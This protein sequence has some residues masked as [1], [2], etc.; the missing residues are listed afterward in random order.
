MTQIELI[1][2][3]WN[4][5]KNEKFTSAEV[6]VYMYLLH[7]IH[8]PGVGNPVTIP[9]KIICD[10]LKI[11]EPTLISVMNS[12]E[13]KEFL[14]KIKPQIGVLGVFYYVVGAYEVTNVD[15]F[16]HLKILSTHLKILSTHLNILST[17]L[18]I[19]STSPK[20]KKNENHISK[21]LTATLLDLQVLSEQNPRTHTR[22]RKIGVFN[23]KDIRED[24]EKNL[25]DITNHEDI[26]S[27]ISG[28]K[29]TTS[30]TENPIAIIATQHSEYALVEEEEKVRSTL[31]TSS[32]VHLPKAADETH[33]NNN[34]SKIIYEVVQPEIP[35]IAIIAKKTAK[36][37]EEEEEKEMWYDVYDP[38]AEKELGSS[39]SFAFW[40]MTLLP[41]NLQK[42]VSKTQF[43]GWMKAY[44]QLIR[45][46]K[47]QPSD[48]AKVCRYA[49]TDEFWSTNFYSPAK[50]RK[51]D[52]QN[53]VLYFDRFYQHLKEE[54][55]THAKQDAD[56]RAANR[57]AKYGG[58]T[59]LGD[60]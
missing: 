39:L 19:L 8:Q 52:N 28:R 47:R 37:K 32:P 10:F 58:D 24:K 16:R 6:D 3:L 14:V 40:F 23:D 26:I 15:F 31:Q 21:V 51:R 12:L 2:Q 1:N 33:A 60:K 9:N 25:T 27:N 50:L 34:G 55:G 35:A 43:D 54:H 56:I 38:N 53:G 36:Q 17:D 7:Q 45:I 11:S 5:R 57:R 49:R 44:D 22:G 18:K 41:E 59:Q 42:R 46:D 29:S 48:I 30:S 13:N 20:F 4:R